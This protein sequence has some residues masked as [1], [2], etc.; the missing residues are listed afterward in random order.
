MNMLNP[1][2]S[3]W[4]SEK[5]Q[6]VRLLL[7]SPGKYAIEIGCFR[8]VTSLFLAEACKAAGKILI[9]ID[10]WNNSQDWSDDSVYYYFLETIAPVKDQIV[11]VRA[12]SDA[13]LPKLP[14][15]LKT[16]GCGLIFVDGDHSYE[17]AKRDLVNY[18]PLL[19]TGGVMAVHDVFD[20]GW[21]GVGQAVEEFIG[22]G[23]SVFYHRYV[24][25]PQE[26][27]DYQHGVSG[28]AWWYK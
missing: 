10:P 3:T 26:R 7:A 13:A 23:M 28:L 11:V 25:T 8:G 17:G 6:L 1:Q 22:P 4:P 12:T 24:P 21:K 15:D 27:R 2:F 9:C 18:Y 19:S 16:A 20:L 5:A 14:P